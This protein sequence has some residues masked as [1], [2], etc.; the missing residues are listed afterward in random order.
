MKHDTWLNIIVDLAH[1]S[2]SLSVLKCLY[3]YYR[4]FTICTTH[5]TLF[6]VWLLWLLYVNTDS[7]II[8]HH[9]QPYMMI[10]AFCFTHPMCVFF[11][12]SYYY[13]R[14]YYKGTCGFCNQVTNMKCKQCSK[15]ISALV[16]KYSLM[17]R[18]ISVNLKRATHGSYLKLISTAVVYSLL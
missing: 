12:N 13:I 16:K 8:Y 4:A 1:C 10:F 9:V 15:N 11:S 2:Y 17:F 5:C 14:L 6:A 18:E 7:A 3:I